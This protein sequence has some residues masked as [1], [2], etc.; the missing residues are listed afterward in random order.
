VKKGALRGAFVFHSGCIWAIFAVLLLHGLF[1]VFLASQGADTL[2]FEHA[3]GDLRLGPVVAA[4]S[5]RRDFP[6]TARLGGTLRFSH[7]K[8]LRS[9]LDLSWHHFD[10]TLPAHVLTGGAGFDW[11]PTDRLPLELGASL[12]LFYVRSHSGSKRHLTDGGE[13]EFGNLLRVA[14][15]VWSQGNWSLDLQWQ[16]ELAWTSPKVS[17]FGWASLGLSRRLW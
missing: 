17:A 11:T 4:G 2:P 3:W 6:A 10:G 9:R 15:P 13:T 16:G 8:D 1:S 14:I 7:W 5:L 12:A